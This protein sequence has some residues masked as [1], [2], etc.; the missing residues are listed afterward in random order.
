MG[1]SNPFC[2]HSWLR[3]S[4]NVIRFSRLN[5]SKRWTRSLH[6]TNGKCKSVKNV[7]TNRD[8]LASRKKITRRYQKKIKN[9]T[10]TMT[11]DLELDSCHFFSFYYTECL[12]GTARP[13][14]EVFL[15]AWHT[16]WPRWK[17]NKYERCSIKKDGEFFLACKWNLLQVTFLFLLGTLPLFTFLNS[18]HIDVL[19]LNANR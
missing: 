1:P 5:V 11:N 17:K 18:Y 6:A 4:S 12:C 19:V 7:S 15:S 8:F 9:I 14:R 13:S 3:T 10:Y 16:C 2:N